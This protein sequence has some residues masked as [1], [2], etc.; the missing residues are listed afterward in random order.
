MVVSDLTKT[1]SL[2]HHTCFSAQW[3]FHF[4][5]NWSLFLNSLE[6]EQIYWLLSPIKQTQPRRLCHSRWSLDWAFS[7]WFLCIG[8][9]VL[10]PSCYEKATQWERTTGCEM[11]WREKQEKNQNTKYLSNPLKDSDCSILRHYLS[12]TK[13]YNYSAEQK[14]STELWDIL[15]TSYLFKPL[16]LGVLVTQEKIT[17]K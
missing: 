13:K 12:A 4:P 7:S 14:Q 16:S 1:Q 15:T 11:P 9:A 8:A 3:D 17:G 2:S 10:S 6:S 5:K